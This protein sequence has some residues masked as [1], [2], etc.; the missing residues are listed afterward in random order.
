[1]SVDEEVRKLGGKLVTGEEALYTFHDK[2]GKLYG[3][4][5]LHVDDFFTTGTDQ[6]FKTVSDVL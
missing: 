5:G 1:M 3:L 2:N 4:I 6:F